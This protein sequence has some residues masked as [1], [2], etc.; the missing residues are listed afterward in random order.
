VVSEQNGKWG[1]AIEVPGTAALNVDGLARVTSV[2][3]VSAG[4]CAA[5]GQYRNSMGTI[6]PF[7]VSERNGSW[8]TAIT[9]PVPNP[10]GFGGDGYIA[11]LSC[12]S[13]GNCT[14]AGVGNL[15]AVTYVFV[16][17]E[18]RGHW[19]QIQKIRG[20]PN[21]V[22]DVES[23]SCAS[24]GNCAVG[25]TTATDGGWQA[26]LASEKNGSWSRAFRVPGLAPDTNSVEAVTSVS[27]PSAGNCLAGGDG[28]YAFLVSEKRG[29]WGKAVNVSRNGRILAVSC[30]SAGNCTAAGTSHSQ[31][32]AISERNGRLGKPRELPGSG[33]LN[34]GGTAQVNAISCTA[35]GECTVAGIYRNSAH[36]DRGFV[37]SQT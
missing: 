22:T 3:C 8:G 34:V 27:C 1:T 19:G 29:R 31:A 33:A 37:D 16:I 32:F 30:R 11:A 36:H 14:G 20:V 28:K 26:F 25:W 9:V 23:L 12:T 35:T 7:V 17:T 6:L 4:N 21:G 15:L 13:V 24:A 18:K 10:G 5:G 2:S